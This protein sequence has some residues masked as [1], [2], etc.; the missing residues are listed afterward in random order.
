MTNRPMLKV[1]CKPDPE[2]ITDYSKQF[3]KHFRDFIPDLYEHFR[4]LEIYESMYLLDWVLSLFSKVLP[5]EPTTRIWDH[6][7][8]NDES[9]VFKTAL[10]ILKYYK[11]VLLNQD[12]ESCLKLLKGDIREV[13]EDDILT[14]IYSVRI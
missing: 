13:D 14:A 10:G 1:F 12:L 6:Y 11:S 3:S 9:F 2:K 4:S 8:L 5:L 7:F